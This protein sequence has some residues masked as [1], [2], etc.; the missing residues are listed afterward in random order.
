MIPADHDKY[1]FPYNLEDRVKD[2]IKKVNKIINRN[3]NIKV[4]KHK[5][6]IFSEKRN[7]E[8]LKYVIVL[9]NSKYVK[10]NEKQIKNLGFKLVNNN[11]ELLLE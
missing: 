9:E 10:E 6:G 1:S 5:N 3:I 8:L 7:S 2:R 11:W 4:N